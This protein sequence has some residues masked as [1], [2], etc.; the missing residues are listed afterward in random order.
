MRSVASNLLADKKST[1]RSETD[2]GVGMG[3]ESACVTFI[4]TMCS[5]TSGK[6]FSRFDAVRIRS[7]KNFIKVGMAS[8]D[9]ADGR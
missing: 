9:H 3:K 1:G 7:S 2:K 8:E 5:S 4:A 6:Y